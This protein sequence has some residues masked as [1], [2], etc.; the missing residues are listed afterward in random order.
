MSPAEIKAL[1]ADR[2]R[3]DA[4]EK[5]FWTIILYRNHRAIVCT[6]DE[7]Q[8]HYSGTTARNAVDAAIKANLEA[9]KPK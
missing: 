7:G 6:F 1:Q 4:V 5:N 9:P 8:G 2:D 3:W